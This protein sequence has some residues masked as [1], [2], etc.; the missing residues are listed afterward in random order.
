TLFV[1]DIRKVGRLTWTAFIVMQCWMSSHAIIAFFD[2]FTPFEII[3]FKGPAVWWSCAAVFVGLNRERWKIISPL[4]YLF[5][6]AACIFALK[7]IF[8][9]QFASRIESLRALF[10]YMPIMLWTAPWLL[11]AI[12]QKSK[13]KM[14]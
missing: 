10:G 7:A 8:S 14:L 2:G 5:S 1:E 4:L 12:F 9:N 13:L 6:I 11:I 3:S